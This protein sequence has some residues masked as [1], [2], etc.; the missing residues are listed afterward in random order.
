MYV[1]MM[2]RKMQKFNSVRFL[3]EIKITTKKSY[4]LFYFW[5]K[6]EEKIIVKASFCSIYF[7]NKN[8][9]VERY[10]K[11]VL[12]DFKGSFNLFIII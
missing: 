1:N 3:L 4:F 7:N 5:G 8:F 11:K 2:Q 10:I 9:R 6:G 12:K